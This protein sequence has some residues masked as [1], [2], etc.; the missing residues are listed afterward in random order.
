MNLGVNV[1]HL[2]E[3]ET[4]SREAT[5][6]IFV[7][8]LSRILFRRDWVY[9]K[10]SS[11]SQNLFRSS[12]MAENQGPTL[13]GKN[14]LPWGANSFLLELTPF[15]IYRVYPVPFNLCI[16]S[17]WEQILSFCVNHFSEGRQYDMVTFSVVVIYTH[18]GD[19]TLSN[20]FRLAPETVSNILE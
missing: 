13:K 3:T 5:M 10:V 8:L 2:K 19:V 4:L 14:L 9:R 1:I 16:L 18:S 7:S 12:K 15:Q 20:C 11:E 6:F 17:L